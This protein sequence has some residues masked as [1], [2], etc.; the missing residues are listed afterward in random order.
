MAL[1]FAL[2]GDDYKNYSFK[3]FIYIERDMHY[4]F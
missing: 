1:F 4:V 2:R 3:K